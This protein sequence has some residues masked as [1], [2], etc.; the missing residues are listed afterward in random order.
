MRVKQRAGPLSVH[1]TAGTHVVLL[2]INLRE[3]NL[4]GLLGFAIERTDHTENERYWLRGFRT[5]SDTEPR[6]AAGASVSLRMH[7]LQGFLW[8]DFTA[9]PAHRYTYRI[10]ALRGHPK[11]LEESQEVEVQ[12]TTE[13]EHDGTH[14]VYFNRGIAGSQAY[15]RRFGNRHPDDVPD[16]QAYTWLSRGL[17][18]ALSRFITQAKD[19]SWGLRASVYEFT[20]PSIL[21]AFA[22]AKARGADVRIV[23]DAKRNQ[24]PGADGEPHGNP[25]DRNLTAIAAA[26]L[27]ALTLPRES[28]ARSISHNKFIVLLHHGEPVAVL[29]GSTNLTPGGLYGHSNVAHVVREPSVATTFLRYWEQLAGDPEARSLRQ[30]TEQATPV[31]RVPPPLGCTPLFSPRASLEA[32]KWYRDRMR[33]ARSGVFLTAAFGVNDLLEEVLAEDVDF[34]R[35]VLLD[36]EDDH[37]ELLR[38]DRDNRI[39]VGSV[40]QGDVLERWVRER[41]VPGL[42]GHVK[43]IHTKYLLIDPLGPAPLVITGS[44]NFSDASTRDNDENMLVIRGDTRVAD[45]YLGEFMRLF[46]HFYFRT[47]VANRPSPR[48]NLSPDDSWTRAYYSPGSF[49]SRERLLFAGETRGTRGVARF[50]AP[51]A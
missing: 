35:Y 43:Y 9:K 3:R 49:K 28:N 2:G 7:P 45:I 32:L 34:P 24:R 12:V 19:S 1:A 25:R 44:A 27:Q 21:Q 46:N 13:L 51:G 23:F 18:E 31:P 40:L 15:A 42:N 8:S 41:T 10:V 37:M 16:G 33:E 47:S 26:N 30:W 22:Q 17:V 29:T 11:H 5:F 4:A 50:P 20:A 39:A 38:R 14:S 48:R 36:R 6:L